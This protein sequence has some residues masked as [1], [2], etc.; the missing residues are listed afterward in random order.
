MPH[1]QLHATAKLFNLKRNPLNPTTLSL[2][3]CV[4]NYILF[5]LVQLVYFK[6][7]KPVVL[8]QQETKWFQTETF[9]IVMFTQSFQHRSKT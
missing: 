6:T 5:S 7:L 3:I 4:S 9:K 1:K 2:L 8:R